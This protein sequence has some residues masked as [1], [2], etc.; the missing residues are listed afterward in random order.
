[1]PPTA[2]DTTFVVDQ[3]PSLDTGCTFRSGGPLRF[4][5]TIDRVVGD[6]NA[7]GTLVRGRIFGQEAGG[8]NDGVPD[9]IKVDTSGNLF[10]TGPQG[11]WVWDAEGNHLGTIVMPESAARSTSRAICPDVFALSEKMSTITRL[12]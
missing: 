8:K 9:G 5:I 12:F 11:I 6:V 4:T 7:D 1:M 2:T 10:V 3:A